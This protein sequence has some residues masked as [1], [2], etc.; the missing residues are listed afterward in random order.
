MDTRGSQKHYTLLNLLVDLLSMKEEEA[1]TLGQDLSSIKFAV[2]GTNTFLY[3]IYLIY[4]I[5]LIR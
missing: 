3:L 1:L 5:N 4:L 2:E